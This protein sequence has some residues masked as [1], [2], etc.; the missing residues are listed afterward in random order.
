[1]ARR[2]EGTYRRILRDV[3]EAEAEYAA[4]SAQSYEDIDS[5]LA[6]LRG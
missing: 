3:R 1:V 6:D 2:D 4:G 5:L